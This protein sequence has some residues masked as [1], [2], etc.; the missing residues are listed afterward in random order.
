[1][2]PHAYGLGPLEHWNR[3]FETRSRPVCPRFSVMPSYVGRGL[4]VG[5][6]PVQGALLECL[7]RIH[8]FRC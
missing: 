7:K 1:M 2:Y 3:G 6:S 8:S 5:R 4:V